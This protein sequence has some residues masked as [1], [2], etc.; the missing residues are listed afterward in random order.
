MT[1]VIIDGIRYLPEKNKNIK[2]APFR[3]LISDARKRKN[4]TLQQAADH[5]GTDKGHLWC[6]EDGRTVPGLY[7]LQK[8]LKHYGTSFE[9]IQSL[10]E[11][12]E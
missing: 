12:G 1:Q 10:K 6:M 3:E 9:E 7:L 2:T 8:I 5:I 11:L 4:E